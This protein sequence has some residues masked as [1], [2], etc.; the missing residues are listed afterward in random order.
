MLS[1]DIE[2]MSWFLFFCC[3]LIGFQMFNSEYGIGIEG[4]ISG[5]LSEAQEMA[6]C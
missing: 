6:N 2:V 4:K 3:S 1:F 5:C